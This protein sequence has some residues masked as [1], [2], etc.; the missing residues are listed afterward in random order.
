MATDGS[1][2]IEHAPSGAYTEEWQL[3]PGSRDQLTVTSV[4]NDTIYRAGDIAVVVR[5]RVVPIPR[6]ARLP[7]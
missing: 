6:L 2:M 5:D 4:G 1:V 7:D 3:V